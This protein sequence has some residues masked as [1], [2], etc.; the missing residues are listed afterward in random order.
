MRYDLGFYLAVI[1]KF[2]RV[3]KGGFLHLGDTMVKLAKIIFIYGFTYFY[4]VLSGAEKFPF[5]S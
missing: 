3:G 5:Q 4:P 1:G 2:I